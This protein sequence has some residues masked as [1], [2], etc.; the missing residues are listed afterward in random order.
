MTREQI[1]RDRLEM[2]K[3]NLYC[4]AANHLG[5]VA[6]EGFEAEHKQAAA[7]IELLEAWLREFPG[8]RID[9]TMEFVG[10]ING[11]SYGRTYDDQ[12][13]ANDIE[14]EVDTGAHYLDGDRRIFRVGPEVQ[15]WFFGDQSRCGKYD[16]EKARRESRL[17]KITVDRIG[18]IRSMWWAVEE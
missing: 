7:E 13:I 8:S 18:Y 1:L 16:I 17:I 9:S 15:D 3:H 12:P 6:K 5:T 2:A 4:Y 11:V 10:H 14:F